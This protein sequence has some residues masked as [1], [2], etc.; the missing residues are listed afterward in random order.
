MSASDMIVGCSVR[1][2]YSIIHTFLLLTEGKSEMDSYSCS[3][4]SPEQNPVVYDRLSWM[5][6]SYCYSIVVREC[7]QSVVVHLICMYTIRMKYRRAFLMS[8]TNHS[9]NED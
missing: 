7:L 4:E 1:T 8:P 9:F 2:T 5:N 6:T 3:K